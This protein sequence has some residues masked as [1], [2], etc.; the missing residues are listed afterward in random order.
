MFYN[1]AISNG[2]NH[3]KLG[4][5]I[6]DYNKK[7]MELLEE[8]GNQKFSKFIYDFAIRIKKNWGI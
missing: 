2:R 3:K 4:E 8:M 5:Y 1:K 7:L 6:M